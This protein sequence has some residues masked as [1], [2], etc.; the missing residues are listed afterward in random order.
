METRVSQRMLAT[1]TLKLD[2][3]AI[4][5]G[6]GHTKIL[7]LSMSENLGGPRLPASKINTRRGPSIYL[8]LSLLSLSAIRAEEIKLN[9]EDRT[10]NPKS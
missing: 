5:W 1:P 4:I 7:L 10:P 9:P 6:P 2:P 8:Q 3:K